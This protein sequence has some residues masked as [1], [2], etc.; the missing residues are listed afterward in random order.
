MCIGDIS[1]RRGPGFTAI[2]VVVV[3]LVLAVLAAW[4]TIG[5]GEFSNW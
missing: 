4:G 2:F 1:F 5:M 3:L